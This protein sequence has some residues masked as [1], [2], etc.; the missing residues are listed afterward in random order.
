MATLRSALRHLAPAARFVSKGG[1]RSNSEPI[2]TAVRRK[3]STG[4]GVFY[5]TI[6][7]DETFDLRTPVTWFAIMGTAI[8]ATY[9]VKVQTIDHEKQKAGGHEEGKKKC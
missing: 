8:G 1:G 2:F 6:L 4:V 3:H 7:W 5:S 9:R